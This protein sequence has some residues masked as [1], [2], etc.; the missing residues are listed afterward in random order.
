MTNDV[1]KGRHP[2]HKNLYQ[3]Y[4]NE[5]KK[6]KREKRKVGEEEMRQ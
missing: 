2:V 3:M 5:K 4:T 6:E 1:K